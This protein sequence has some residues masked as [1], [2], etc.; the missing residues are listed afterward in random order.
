MSNSRFRQ[1]NSELH[2]RLSSIS[3]IVTVIAGW[4]DRQMDEFLDPFKS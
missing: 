2:Q 1:L 3:L 4:V